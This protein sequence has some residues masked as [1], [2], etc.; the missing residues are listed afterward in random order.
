MNALFEETAQALTANDSG[1]L[2]A[3]VP[4]ADRISVPEHEVFRVVGRRNLLDAILR[5]TASNLR[6][7]R[8]LRDQRRIGDSGS[9]YEAFRQ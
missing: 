6:L 7:L 8:R 3:L 5:E 9:G 1:R 2:M 4:L